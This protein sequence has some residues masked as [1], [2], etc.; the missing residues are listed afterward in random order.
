VKD[1]LDFSE[2]SHEAVIIVPGGGPFV[3]FIR[4][5]KINDDHA[6]WMAILGMNQYGYLLA[7]SA[8]I[9][10]IESF[11]ELIQSES[12][13]VIFLPY[14]ELRRYDD[15]PHTWS[16]T[17]DAIAAWVASKVSLS[18][19]IIATDV[20]GIYKNGSLV[21]CI[22]T[23]ELLS[24]GETCVD[25][26]LPIFLRDKKMSCRIVDGK[27]SANI[28]NVLKGLDVGTRIIP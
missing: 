26:F 22:R 17:S 24:M 28:T 6:H 1:L 5:F 8:S 23:K 4:K 13:I 19:L 12:K 10:L 9:S 25:R 14:K 16:V 18:D 21:D 7:D 27:Y 2:K 11:D 15:L 3:D 20:E